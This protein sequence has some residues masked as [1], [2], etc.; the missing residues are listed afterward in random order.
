MDNV[1]HSMVA[2]VART[3]EQAIF[4]MDIV[5]GLRVDKRFMKYCPD[6]KA[7]ACM[8]KVIGIILME[9]WELRPDADKFREVIDG[10][11]ARGKCYIFKL[12]RVL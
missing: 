1:E 6:P 5:A 12:T 10:Y 3:N 8:P 7:L 2:V 4:N 11:K 9:G